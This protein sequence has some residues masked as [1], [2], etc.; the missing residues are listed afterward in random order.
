MRF[1][2]SLVISLFSVVNTVAQEI[3][4]LTFK[5]F[6]PRL[7][8]KDDT[9]HVINFWATWCKPCVEELPYFEKL[10][11]QY[12]MYNLKVTLVSLDF[13]SQFDKK[14]VPFV[15]DNNIQSEVL[16]LNAPNYNDWISQ[17]N[18]NWGGSIPATLI[19]H[20][21]S[22]TRMFLEKQF[23]SYEEIEDLVK[24]FIND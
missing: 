20:K 10:H 23:S 18:K 5:E 12:S 8:P 17:V 15:S 14:L 21:P 9:I 3:P 16:L 1:F 24:P 6:A 2:F 11:E 4:I 22:V 7:E 19:I 13:K